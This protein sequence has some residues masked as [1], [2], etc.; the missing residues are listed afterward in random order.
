MRKLSVFDVESSP[1]YI[2]PQKKARYV[3]NNIS[4]VLSLCEKEYVCMNIYIH[5]SGKTFEK[6]STGCLLV[7][8]LSKWK[9]SMR[10]TLFTVCPLL[11]KF[12]LYEDFYLSEKK[13]L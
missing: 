4:T 3:E 6:L 1:I 13:Y 2:I 9:L 7:D 8:K 10:G 5:I 11:L 12:K